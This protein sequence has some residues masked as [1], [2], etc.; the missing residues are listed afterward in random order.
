MS[1]G[2]RVRITPEFPILVIS[3]D[4]TIQGPGHGGRHVWLHQRPDR[5]GYLYISTRVAGSPR[6]Q[7]RIAVQT[8]VCTAFHGPRPSPAHQVAHANG[9]NTDNRAENLRWA[10]SLENHAD[11]VRHGRTSAGAKNPKVKLTEEQV[12]QIRRLRSEGVPRA[13][14]ALRYGVHQGTVKS[15]TS[16]TTWGWLT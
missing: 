14:V 9:I 11:R 16:R 10:T 4:G 8:V 3:A 13:E 5:Q 12:R 15:I 6:R 7:D 2:I 1:V